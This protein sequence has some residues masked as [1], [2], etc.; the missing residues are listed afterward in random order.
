MKT[1]TTIILLFAG[2]YWI[3]KATVLQRAATI[4]AVSDG[5]SFESKLRIWADSKVKEGRLSP[6]D[7]TELFPHEYGLSLSGENP[8][9]NFREMIS[10][11]SNINSLP[12][13]PGYIMLITGFI[14]LIPKKTKDAE[15]V[16]PEHPSGL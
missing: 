1:V 6:A 9:N 13:W 16:P 14:G 15:H 3:A 4:A 7:V 8:S 5:M 12:A 2:S 10:D 11:I